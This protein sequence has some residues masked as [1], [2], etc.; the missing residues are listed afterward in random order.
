ML[1][2]QQAYEIRASIQ[3]YLN[4]T[5]SFRERPLGEAF[6]RFLDDERE[7]MFKGPYISLKLPFVQA[8]K[9]EVMP[10]D[11]QVPITPYAH[12][13]A[14]FHRLSTQSGRQPQPTILTTGTG[15][16]KTESFLFPLLD[17]CNREASRPGIK[18]I[19]LYPMNALATDQA[20]R[21]ARMIYEHPELR[22]KVR[23]GLFIG[24]GAK[25]GKFPDTMGED[26]LVEDRSTILNTP[27]DIL[28]T[29]FK[30]LDYALMRGHFHSLWQHNLRD[31][32]LLRFLVLD[33]LHTYDGAQGSDVA[34]LLRR[35]KLK[36]QVP[37]RQ[38]CAVG[39]SATIGS[40]EEAPALL[41]EYASKLY[42]EPIDE[43]ALIAEQR[44]QPDE[45]FGIPQEEMRN[46]LPT[47][48]QLQTSRLRADDSYEH[49]RKKQLE[50]WGLNPGAD[51][52]ELGRELCNIRL[53]RDLTEL[54]SQ[55][56]RSMGS[57]LQQ[58]R[59]RNGEFR[60]IPEWDE[61]QQFSPQE[62]LLRSLLSLLAEAR[63]AVEGAS[64]VRHMPLFYLQVQ[65]WIREL[66]GVLR[67][68]EVQ[69]GFVWSDKRP[70]NS[71]E[72]A[73]PAWYCRECG[74]S[75]WLAVKNEGSERFE[76]DHKD[77]FSKYFSNNKNLYFLSPRSDVH[78]HVPGY[79]PSD[80]LEGYLSLS[81]LHLHTNDAEGRLGVLAYRIVKNNHAEHICPQCNT[82]NTMGIVGGRV[83]TMVSVGTSQVLAS[84]LDEQEEQ[85]RKLLIFSN[86]VQDAAHLAGYVEARNY[87]FAFRTALQRVINLQEEP[88]ALDALQEAFI[89]YWKA[90]TD[91]KALENYLYRF[92]PPD[93]S[94]E[95]R[96]EDFR[97]ARHQYAPGFVEEF[98]RRVFW[99]IASEFGYNARIGRT[100]EKTGS[101]AAGF[102]QA[103]LANVYPLLQPWMGENKLEYVQEADFLRFLQGFLHRIRIR[104]GISH[105]FLAKFR[106]GN[107]KLW[108]LN[109]NRDQRHFLNRRFGPR[110]RF[111]RLLTT[112]AESG[113]VTDSTYSKQENWFH[114]Y[115]TKSFPLHRA[116]VEQLNEFYEQLV[117]TL[118]LPEVGLLDVEHGRERNYSLRTD[119]IEV[120]NRVAVLHC[121]HCGDELTV[122]AHC[123]ESVQGSSC[124]L[125]R[126]TGHYQPG[127]V[128]EGD[129]YYRQI[130]SRRRAPRVYAAD[131][132]GLLA[133][134]DR[135]RVE[136]D[137]RERPRFN[138]L[139]TLVATSTLEMGIDIGDL[140][141]SMNADVPP[142]PSNFLQR[143]GRAGRK[144]GSALL[145]NFASKDPHD[146]YYFDEPLDMMAGLVGTPGCFLDA[147]EILRRHYLAYCIDCWSTDNPEENRIPPKI[148]ALKLGSESVADPQ[149]FLN[150]L[151][152]YVKGQEQDLLQAFRLA[153]AG[154]VQETVFEELERSFINE[155]F[156]LQA[157][158][159][160]ERLQQA[161]RQL[162]EERRKIKTYILEKKLAENDLEREE[163]EAEMR[164]LRKTQRAI[165]NR[166]VLEHMTNTGLLPN[167][168]FPETGVTLN[169]RILGERSLTSE[170]PPK[171]LNLELVRPARQALKELAPDNSFYTQGFKLPINGLQIVNWKEEVRD[172]RFCS[173]CDH[174]EEDRMP[175]M[176][177]C[178]KCGHESWRAASNRHRFVQM[179]AVKSFSKEATARLDD[180]S[181]E[182][183]QE[184]I[185][186]SRHFRFQPHARQGALALRNIPFGI[187][188]VREVDLIDVNAGLHAEF[189]DKSRSVVI[190]KQT[191]PAN[192]YIT[193]R[194]CGR[195]SFST[196]KRGDNNKVQAKQ[197]ADFHYGYCPHREQAY[198]G[199]PDEVFEEL[200][201]Y[202]EM[203]TEALKIL[204]PV[205]EVETEDTL[206]MFKAGL[207]RGLKA[208]YRGEPSHIQF[209]E[210]AEFNHQ[211]LK[212]DRYLVMYDLIPGGTGYLE[213]LFDPDEFSK[214][215]K[216]AW[217]A[218]RDCGCQHLNKDGCY[219]CIYSYSNQYMRQ[220]L[221]RARAEKLFETIYRS[222]D[223]WEVLDHG[224]SH[225]SNT[226]KIEESEL[227]ER[228]IRALRH[229]CEQ[230]EGCRFQAVNAEGVQCYRLHLQHQ[231]R[232]LDYFITPQYNL[233][234][235]QGVR[236]HS[237]ADFLIRL[238]GG[239]IADQ[240]LSAEECHA[241]SS[242][243]IYLDGYQY[244]ATQACFRFENDLE[245]RR[246][247]RENPEY[248]TWTL[249]WSDIDHFEQYKSDL[250][251]NPDTLKPG[252]TWLSN[253]RQ[254]SRYK[255]CD[256][257]LLRSQ[258]NLER[259]LWLLHQG[260]DLANTS[261]LGSIRLA[262]LVAHT[263]QLKYRWVL[264]GQVE[265]FLSGAALQHAPAPPSNGNCYFEIKPARTGEAIR[266][267]L[268]EHLHRGDQKSRIRIQ[269][270]EDDFPKEEWEHFW[271]LYNLLQLTDPNLELLVEKP[272]LVPRPTPEPDL[273]LF[274]L[275]D[276]E[277]HPLI[278][279]L[280]AAG[281]PI[282]EEGSYIL[283]S[284]KD[285]VE[286][287]AILG[288]EDAGLIIGPLS[289][290]DSKAFKKRGYQV[291]EPGELRPEEF[292]QRIKDATT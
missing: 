277:Y 77:I 38:L 210:Y 108:D 263:E 225:V 226:G 249:S 220:A 271:R 95:V 91:N 37:E 116:H 243:A 199:M 165:E 146:L 12:Q 233:G 217:E 235:A 266:Y 212:T 245:K 106:Q 29:N 268:L 142:L 236:H 201:L 222:I 242:L 207:E 158:R 87:R 150:R 206:S 189:Q 125:Y 138:S 289:D 28:L 190:H 49:Y 21:L 257:S 154:Q 14:A 93:R 264:P 79:S 41:A 255:Q 214:V 9:Q 292:I 184:L 131:H 36:L 286:A 267:L 53:V 274:E 117:Q 258:N 11:I 55:Q 170:A 54:C 147:R 85:G 195:S 68:L 240:E 176:P 102:K 162:G 156:Y 33:E 285:Q 104:G 136:K 221:S 137:F 164:N 279:A 282:G 123:A 50:L 3:E 209:Q 275:Y 269:L 178:P 171:S 215:L 155:R 191:I 110:S 248:A 239:R 168:A 18:C 194:V 157:T 284:K 64:G 20:G 80:T 26:H 60:K 65:L 238:E 89:Q 185:L 132:T 241:Y 149:F 273:S 81:D 182:R 7:G 78:R 86:G 192:G 114:A 173:E 280:Q 227:E 22:G 202:R 232:H 30:M 40:G 72:Q 229:Y 27:P 151:F 237:R 127:Q 42:G 133:R 16:G 8:E 48:Y 208:Y 5:F 66:S 107:F 84:D 97:Q 52:A 135:E 179:Q 111:P 88:L 100:L 224:L 24:M 205:Q 198:Q 124:L 174:L 82:R 121:S 140:N 276:P 99:E 143:V 223:S 253:L 219:R 70:N 281:I 47:L 73:L 63:Q 231:N 183:S 71:E 287:E 203:K 246:A 105:P 251:E 101:S 193:C 141:V 254:L 44:Q 129:N 32:E 13:L 34:N 159:V 278:Q 200:Y 118:A 6:R 166:Q 83:S 167:Y 115:F 23:A 211:T 148:K 98:D 96:M 92:F 180:S 247:I 39:T 163:M 145:L 76:Q 75:G 153:Y 112:V 126:C 58:L 90:G 270:T 113:G 213:K 169:A 43:G 4:A 62:A 181:E 139:N 228:F 272:R 128:T 122:A 69:P 51:P 216:L 160:F 74:A 175:V 218:I 1:T 265:E 260:A 186:R 172:F 261:L 94:G 283:M 120:S 197:A 188:F 15:S 19:I 56:P 61:R 10:L 144:S 250:L 119:A 259:L 256:L 25:A 177:Q 288:F 196:H 204:L 67:K 2:L 31:P 252:N 57:L 152:R 244:H 290:D 262:L 234:P 161:Y 291:F 103:R 59:D 187:E 45:F 46:S 109:W 230:T 130:Y 134:K 17:Y 35:L